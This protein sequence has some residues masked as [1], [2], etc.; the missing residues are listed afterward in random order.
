[1]S[2]CSVVSRTISAYLWHWHQNQNWWCN[3]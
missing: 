3:I 1:M 2:R